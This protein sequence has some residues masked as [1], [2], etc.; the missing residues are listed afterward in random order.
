VAPFAGHRLQLHRLV[1]GSISWPG[2]GE[3][4]LPRDRGKGLE[5]D[6]VRGLWA[7]LAQRSDRYVPGAGSFMGG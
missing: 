4:E 3:S 7:V 1:S 6:S 5:E 2:I